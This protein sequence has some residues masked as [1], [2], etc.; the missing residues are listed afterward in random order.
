MIV[1]PFV[2][3]H[4]YHIQHKKANQRVVTV[5]W[6]NYK[7]MRENPGFQVLDDTIYTFHLERNFQTITLTGKHTSDKVK[8]AFFQTQLRKLIAA[9]DSLTGIKVHFGDSMP[10]NSLIKV[11]D[12][13]KTENAESYWLYENNLY[14]WYELPNTLFDGLSHC[15]MIDYPVETDSRNYFEKIWDTLWPIL[16]E[17]WHIL[18]GFLLLCTLGLVYIRKQFWKKH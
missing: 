6:L 2:L 12:I 4:F 8:L 13:R 1:L 9:H 17:F 5:S 10:Y 11:L 14:V 3:G 7:H 16:S 15:V 18:T